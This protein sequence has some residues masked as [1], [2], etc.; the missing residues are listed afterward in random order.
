MYKLKIVDEILSRLL[1]PRKRIQVID[2]IQKIK[3]WSEIVKR[4]WD[5]DSFQHT[6]LKVCLLGSSR[7]L[8]QKGLEESLAG[9]FELIDVWHWSFAD[10]HAAFGY[11]LEDYILFGGYPGAADLRGDE[12][13]W[14]R[15]IRDAIIEPSINL[16]ILQLETVTKPELLRQTFALGCCYSGKILSGSSEK[17]RSPLLEHRL[18]GGRLR[19]S[20]R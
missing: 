9:R 1:E 4:L 12:D 13:R 11:T 19:A 7:L 2:E 17:Y 5:E 16:D 14:R 18:Q 15:Y 10:M 20:P 6:E 3:G 8:L